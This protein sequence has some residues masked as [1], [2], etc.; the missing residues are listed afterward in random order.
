MHASLRTVGSLTGQPNPEQ[1]RGSCDAVISA[2]GGTETLGFNI[3][4]WANECS[5]FT[6]LSL[7]TLK[8]KEHI[9]LHQLEGPFT[10]FD[11][12][13]HPVISSAHPL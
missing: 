6:M 12:R 8:Y 5:A 1:V 3:F 11:N 4:D 10:F 2:N 7:V 9:H 13:R